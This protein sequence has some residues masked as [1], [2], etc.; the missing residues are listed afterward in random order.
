MTDHQAITATHPEHK[1]Q[2]RKVT[3]ELDEKNQADNDAIQIDA[4]DDISA[5]E[6][7]EATEDS[8]ETATDAVD[9]TYDAPPKQRR[10][11]VRALALVV[12]PAVALVLAMA[13]GYAK[14]LDSSMR[15]A[16]LARAES[17]SAATAS[18]VA[19][20]SY[21]SDSVEKDLAAARD[22][23][24]GKF[25]DAYTQLTHDVVIPGSKQKKI[26]VVANVPAAASVS[27]TPTHAV[28]LLFV[29]Q[30]TTFGNDPPTD[31]ASSVRVTLDR[32]EH[33]WMISDLT[34]V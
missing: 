30:T 9:P 18:T 5:D 6:V 25:R 22:G 13:A 20:L 8:G 12:L 28:V 2:A 32:V 27:A 33:R 17:V 10:R 7:V 26:S 29:D 11:L 19:M 1:G 3:R 31:T 4:T 24:T 23:L 16:Q 21:K 15:D 34:P 14:W